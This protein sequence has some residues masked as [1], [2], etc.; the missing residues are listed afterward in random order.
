[1][2]KV[3]SFGLVTS[4]GIYIN[5]KFYTCSI[6]IQRQWFL[7]ARVFG[8]W[9]VP[10][11]YDTERT[12]HIRIYYNGTLHEATYLKGKNQASK[13]TINHYFHQLNYMKLELKMLKDKQEKLK[14]ENM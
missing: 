14:G 12:E 9:L 4:R 10:V 5:Q 7:H 8:P 6:A 1:M 11:I 3:F 13:R 2:F